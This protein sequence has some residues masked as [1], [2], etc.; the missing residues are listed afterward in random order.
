MKVL[1]FGFG[2][3]GG[4]FASA[5]YYL[6][7]GHELRITDRNSMAKLGDSLAWFKDRGVELVLEQHRDCDFAWADIIVKSPAVSRTSPYLKKARGSVVTDFTELFR[8][9]DI[10]QIKLVMITGTKGKTTTAAAVTHVL[11]QTGHEVMMCGNMGISC[12][13]VLDNLENRRRN[14]E[15]YPDYIVCELS[16]WQIADAFAYCPATEIPRFEVCCMT[17]VYEDHQNYYRSMEAYIND[18]LL[19]FK[20]GA[21]H[22][23]G[24]ESMK[25]ALARAAC[26]S[27][28]KVVTI[29]RTA[30]KT[31][32]S[33]FAPAY[34]IC[35][36][37]GLKH[38]RI[39]SALKTCPGVPHRN[40]MVRFHKNV[41]FINDSAAT[42]PQA[43]DF[44][45]SSFYASSPVFL[46][47]GGT[48]KALGV[49]GMERP[50][51]HVKGIYL[52][53]GS[54]TR[55]KLVPFLKE[56]GLGY[57][58]PFGAL[59]P[60]LKAAYSDAVSYSADKGPTPIV[61]LSPG[62]AS[63]ELFLHEF[64]RGDRFKALVGELD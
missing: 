50:L 32:N 37:L 5:K 3:H 13:A 17:S 33:L 24:T 16:S 18:K 56:A 31:D 45:W 64:D 9:P 54:F 55:E 51:R 1:I 2:L 63:F 7:R 28:S 39:L 15:K 59:E 52:L 21:V 41:I 19:L 57:C 22:I 62:A 14:G 20:H 35:R 30:R 46:I 53:D 43:V 38:D 47:C 60:A 6:D 25:D 27:P 42:V 48:D 26:V 23:V 40:E 34:A 58:G 36:A 4:G 10:G 8:F 49:A 61:L 11:Q 44:T 12:F 29:E